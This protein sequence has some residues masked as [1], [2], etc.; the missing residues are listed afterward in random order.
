MKKS[1]IRPSF[2]RNSGFTLVE[3][4][5]VIA[6]IAVLASVLMGAAG[7]AMK[8]AQRAKTYNTCSQ[9]QS[10][11]MNYFTEYSVYP[12]PT[13]PAP[14]TGQDYYISDARGLASPAFRIVWEC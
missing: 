12:V 6:I 13:V 4:L 10:A 2:A 3:L 14:V 9:I 7:M 5:V 8:A 11:A 1:V